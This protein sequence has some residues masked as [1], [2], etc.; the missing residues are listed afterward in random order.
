MSNAVLK[1]MIKATREAPRMYFAPLV[2]AINGI[3]AEY[4]RLWRTDALRGETPTPQ[5][6]PPKTDRSPK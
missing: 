6:C 4:V 5:S 1:E 2:G 3:K